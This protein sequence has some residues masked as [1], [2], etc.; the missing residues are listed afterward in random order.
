MKRTISEQIQVTNCGY[1]HELTGLEDG[2][3]RVCVHGDGLVALGVDERVV[4]D[5]DASIVARQQGDLIGNSLGISE[6]GNVLA[7]VAEAHHNLLGVGTGQLG[8]GLLS[9]DDQL[10]VGVLLKYT[11]GGLGQTGVDTT[12]ETLVRAGNN[13]QGLLV[14]EGLGFGV[15]EDGVG[16]ATVDT[17]VVHGLLG[18]SKTSRSNN[19][20]G[21]GD[22]L[23]VLNGLETTLDFTQSRE[24][25]GVGGRSASRNQP[26]RFHLHMDIHC[27]NPTVL[28]PHIS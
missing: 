5:F 16:G 17:R 10:G 11:T 8:L 20:H 22:L 14:L 19:L 25:G 18:P 1:R 28:F 6:S 4:Q 12:A 7:D 26:F 15:L 23:D 2:L 9:E 27:P 21:V 3:L 24:V 13:D